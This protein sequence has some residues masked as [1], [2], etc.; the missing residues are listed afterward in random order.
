MANRA[1]DFTY[2]AYLSS[3]GDM[4]GYIT[5]KPYTSSNKNTIYTGFGYDNYTGSY[6]TAHS[7][8][9]PGTYGIYISASRFRRNNAY[10]VIEINTCDSNNKFVSGS[11]A[12]SILLCHP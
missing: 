4:Y 9:G 11:F 12:H 10:L 3:T 5:L 1:T 2:P 7:K 6:T 8:V